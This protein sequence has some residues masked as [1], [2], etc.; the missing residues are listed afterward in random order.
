MSF[1]KA[2]ME[3]DTSSEGSLPLPHLCFTTKDA[4]EWSYIGKKILAPMVRAGTLPLRILSRKYGADVV[5]SEE[6]IDHA[7]L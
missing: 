4:K 3:P 6:I 2:G 7:I 1:R 5:Y